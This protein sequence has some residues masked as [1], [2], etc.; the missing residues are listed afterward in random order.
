MVKNILSLAVL[1]TLTICSF[2]Q[3]NQAGDIILRGGATSVTPDSGKSAIL[4]AGNDST[5]SLTVDDNTQIG[6]A[7]V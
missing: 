4:L 5:M 6:R 2:A 3:A 7:H 1:S